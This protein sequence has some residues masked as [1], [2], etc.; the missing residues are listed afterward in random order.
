T[1]RG[2]ALGAAAASALL[3]PV[4][5]GVAVWGATQ[6]GINF[7]VSPTPPAYV[8]KWVVGTAIILGITGCWF[9]AAVGI[10]AFLLLVFTPPRFRSDPA[11][12]L[13]SVFLGPTWLHRWQ[14]V[15]PPEEDAVWLGAWLASRLDPFTSRVHA[16]QI[17]DGVGELLDEMREFPEYADLAPPFGL[18]IWGKMFH[19]DHGHYVAYTPPHAPGERLGMV[20]ALHG[21]GGNAVLWLHAWRDFADAH[22]FAVVCPSFGYG[23]WD[24]PDSPA[25]IGRC[26]RHA[27]ASLPVDPSRVLLAGLSQ[28][29]AGVG[30]AAAAFPDRFAG[31]ILLSPTTEPMVLDSPAF[32]EDWKGRPVFV[33]Q[34]GKDHNVKPA[35]V[36]T[37]V[38]RMRAAGVAVTYHFD[39]DA[40]H[41]LFFAR[42]HEL[43]GRIADVFGLARR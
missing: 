14:M 19:P 29:G 36:T 31:L 30:R 38:E 9:S 4:W 37:A 10:A 3:L 2:R 5:Y 23:N 12:G 25:A 8:P 41:F 40:D 32:T 20:V 22:G 33:A 27:V 43:F 16:R 28:G 24:Y 34:G 35:G 42:R 39:P 13:A 21:H 17:R 1:W 15:L 7:T 26:L 18:A 11:P 6:F